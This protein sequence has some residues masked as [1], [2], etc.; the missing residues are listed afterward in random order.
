MADLPLSRRRWNNRRGSTIAPLSSA[1]ARR[2]AT[3][4]AYRGSPVKL[5]LLAAAAV[6]VAAPAFADCQSDAQVQAEKVRTA[7]QLLSNQASAPMTEQCRTGS[8]LIAEAKRLNTINRNCQGQ[9]QL[10][11]QDLQRA[12]QRIQAA[13]QEYA[14]QCGS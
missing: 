9:L 8:T 12:D 11:A 3:L 14:T 4:P 6:L 7:Q 2:K 5:V 1:A 10:T 13:D